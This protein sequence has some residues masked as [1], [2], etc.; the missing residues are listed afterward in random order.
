MCGVRTVVDPAQL[1]DMGAKLE[2]LKTWSLSTYKCTRQAITERLGKATRTVDLEI[3]NQINNLRTNQAH[4]NVR[5]FNSNLPLSV[6][7]A[8]HVCRNS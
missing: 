6:L 5:P 8:G 4:Y 2:S 1:G 3:E 7:R